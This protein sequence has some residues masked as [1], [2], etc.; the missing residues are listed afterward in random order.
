MLLGG[1]WHGAAWT[2]LAWGGLHGALLIAERGL[3]ASPAARWGLWR[4]WYGEPP[5]IA[6]T[7]S[8]VCVTWVFFRA[9]TFAQAGAMLTAMTGA[10]GFGGGGMTMRLV[11]G[12][13][14]GAGGILLV[15]A[16]LRNTTLEAA[17]ARLPWWALSAALAAM[18]VLTV[19]TPGEDT[20]FIYFQF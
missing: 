11:G 6:A 2:F 20:A 10:A 7:F 13:A 15:H 17:A 5:L 16:L 8:A 14:V 4:R 3:R 19:L 1:L 12:T 9:G 18:A